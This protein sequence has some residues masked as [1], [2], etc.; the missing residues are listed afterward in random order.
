[1]KFNRRSLKNIVFY[2]STKQLF[3]SPQR[4]P[5][6]ELW[7][8]LIRRVR[9]LTGRTI[10]RGVHLSVFSRVEIAV[11]NYL[12]LTP[13]DLRFWSVHS[14]TLPGPSAPSDPRNML[15]RECPTNRFIRFTRF[16]ERR[17]AVCRVYYSTA[18]TMTSA[19]RDNAVLQ[20]CVLRGRC[21]RARA[22]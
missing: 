9:R 10:R 17:S 13:N 20:K 6:Y 18:P 19:A 7:P 21:R 1:M 2:S 5:V 15:P 4:K 16:C 11:A 3:V 12:P 22:F 14:R 8:R